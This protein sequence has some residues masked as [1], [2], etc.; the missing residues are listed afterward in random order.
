MRF[1]LIFGGRSFE[2]EIS[3]VSAIVLKNTLKSPKEFIFIDEEGLFYHI[4]EKNMRADYF[5]KGEYKKANQLFLGKHGFFYKSMFSKKRLEVDVILDVI[6]GK[7]GE[8]GKLAGM[9]EFF[10][11]P[12]IGPKIDAC[13]LSFNKLYTKAY[14]DLVGVKTL[15]YKTLY[16]GEDISK[17]SFPIILKP[18]RLGSSIGISVVKNEEE[19]AYA[20]DV[21]FEF[22]DTILIEKYQEN[23]K[24][25]NLAGTKIAGEFVFSTAEEP[26]KKGFYN[27]EQKYLDFK[28]DSKR[29]KAEISA[30]LELAMKEAFAKIYSRVFEGSLIRCDFFELDGE[31][32][33]NEINPV[34]GSMAHYLFAD[35]EGI[36]INLA[37][38]ARVGKPPKINYAFLNSIQG[39]KK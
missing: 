37:K 4:L 25:Y 16:L 1:G 35:F 11:I 30:K 39:S 24:E 21:G 28:Q 19:L 18:S 29:S 32:Y 15:P 13:T 36:L 23:I 22:D 3:I 27:F 34:P 31:L 12:F 6:H 26:K 7:D 9:F 33:L 20:L 5:S 8:D 38:Q 17:Q 2:H 10:D 14:A